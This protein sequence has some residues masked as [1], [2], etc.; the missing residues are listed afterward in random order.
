MPR[1]RQALPTSIPIV[2]V[3]ALSPEFRVQGWGCFTPLLPPSINSTYAAGFRRSRET[4]VGPD[5]K[6]SLAEKL[7]PAFY[8]NSEASEWS[9]WMARAVQAAMTRAGRPPEEGP[10]WAVEDI[11]VFTFWVLP[12]A[13]YDI[14]NRIKITH[15]S[16]QGTLYRNDSQIQASFQGKKV[17]HTC[18]EQGVFIAVFPDREID[19]AMPHWLAIKRSSRDVGKGH[20]LRFLADG[21]VGTGV[22]LLAV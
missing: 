2:T 5:G 12:G 16:L 19:S 17:S 3:A 8:K 18:A 9:G 10:W 15:D 14:D 21:I 4:V 22:N 20:I 13:N 6:L 7:R 11:A 1:K